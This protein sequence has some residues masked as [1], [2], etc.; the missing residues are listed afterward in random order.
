MRIFSPSSVIGL[1]TRMD[2][3]VVDV[4]LT[5]PVGVFLSNTGVDEEDEE[6]GVLGEFFAELP[7]LLLLLVNDDL[8]WALFELSGE[9]VSTLDESFFGFLPISFPF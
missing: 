6:A 1:M 7:D 8:T 3:L 9:A 2:G 4:P 5:L